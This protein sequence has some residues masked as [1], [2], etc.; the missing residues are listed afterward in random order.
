[1][2]RMAEITGIFKYL[3]PKCHV[4]H[5]CDICV[6][7]R[8]FFVFCFFVNRMFALE[9]NNC[10]CFSCPSLQITLSSTDSHSRQCHLSIKRMVDI[11]TEEKSYNQLDQDDEPGKY[12]Q[13]KFSKR[14]NARYLAYNVIFK[15][16]NYTMTV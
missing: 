5:F 8:H 13:T 12:M 7:A 10:I 11:P 3:R 14:F 15:R 6:D 16:K 1:M 4:A 2:P 9:M